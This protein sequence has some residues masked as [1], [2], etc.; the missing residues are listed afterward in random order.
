MR[1]AED[2][3][4]IKSKRK[5]KMKKTKSKKLFYL[6]TRKWASTQILVYQNQVVRR[7]W[8][9]VLPN[10]TRSRLTS[11]CLHQRMFVIPTTPIAKLTSALLNRL[12]PAIQAMKPTH[13]GCLIFLNK[14]VVTR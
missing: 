1:G 2:E 10:W 11:N 6:E 13:I 8:S 9:Y 4:K 5:M 14:P 3:I 12:H 7:Y